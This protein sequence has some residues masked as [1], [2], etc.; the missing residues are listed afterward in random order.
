MKRSLAQLRSDAVGIFNAA[1]KSA[2]AANAVTSQVHVNDAAIEVARR[3][4]P[5]ANFR[6]VF[7]VGAGK[8][9]VPMART[10]EMLLGE[11]LTGGIVVAPYGQPQMLQKVRV[12]EAAHPI[13][14][15]A[16]LAGARLI[17]G[18]A[19][20]ASA[21]ELIFVLLS[22]GGSALLPYPLDGLTL[23]DKQTVTQLLL[24]SGATIQQINTVRRHLSELKGGKLARMAD[25]AQVVTLILSDVI[26]DSLEDIA[27]GPTAPD[28]SRYAD[29]LEI[30]RRYRLLEAIP[31]SARSILER[32]SQ[33]EIAETIKP[34]DPVFSRVLNVIVGSNRLATEAARSYAESL[35]YYSTILSNTVQ[36]ESREVAKR[37]AASLK[38]AMNEPTPESI[39]F[40][41][42]GETTVTVRGAGV[43]GRNQEFALAAA[44]EIAGKG[45]VVVLSAG[46]DGIDGPT[47]AAGALVD[48]ATVSRGTSKGYAAAE[49]LLRNDSNHFLNATGDLLI[50][51]PTHTNVMD[52]QVMLAG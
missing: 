29:C 50:T 49:F 12:H 30:V 47:Y 44:L 1:V 40:I 18:I 24:R 31:A 20:Q 17:A 13:P 9:A 26:G 10:M 46:T 4:Y 8:A 34:N 15:L 14:D 21:H 3:V 43:G 2:D 41:S 16:G 39:C 37:H 19:G 51:G 27:S 5:L 11:R 6:S 23:A 52:I 22:G 7:I 35:G 25:P 42:G 38:K 32:G 48:G 33:G 36:G 45:G 28:P